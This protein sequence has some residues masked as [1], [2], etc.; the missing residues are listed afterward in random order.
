MNLDKSKQPLQEDV[1]P[2]HSISDM[3]KALWYDNNGNWYKAHEIVQDIQ[4]S[5]AFWIHAY[6]HRK[7]G[8]LISAL[9]WY[10]KSGQK[11]TIR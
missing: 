9:Y 1:S 3:L 5:D 8:D 6:L 11:K 10:N 7:E 2:P 4:N